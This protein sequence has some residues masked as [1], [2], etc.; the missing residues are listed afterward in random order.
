M[1]KNKNKQPQPRGNTTNNF[2]APIGQY[3]EHV[4]K[5]EAHFDKDMRMQVK[6]ADVKEE[7]PDAHEPVI[8]PREEIFHFVHPELDDKE[9][10]HIHDAVK[11]LVKNQRLPEICEYLKELKKNG[12]VMLPSNSTLMYNELVRLGMPTGEGYTEKHFKNN[13]TK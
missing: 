12:K 13:Y 8:E 4:D 2:Y 7:E 11:R 1:N 10:W 6:N 5:I 9:A 3:I